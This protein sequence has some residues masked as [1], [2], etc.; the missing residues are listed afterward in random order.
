MGEKVQ[1]GPAVYS[2]LDTEWKAALTDG[3]RAP[4]QRF[5]FV[6]LSITNSGG[7]PMHVPTFELQSA[8]GT[9]YQEVTQNMEGV[10]DWLGILRTVQPANTDHGYVVFDVPIAAYKL[11]I[12]ANSDLEN[13]K[14]AL[15]EIP[16]QF[17]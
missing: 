13:E 1:I 17:E 9:R 8:N 4:Q 14:Y 6:R 15:V 16:V 10:R 11:I 12:P 5:L 7:T 3:G 2:V